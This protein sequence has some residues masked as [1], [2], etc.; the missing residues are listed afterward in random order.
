MEDRKGLRPQRDFTPIEEQ[1]AAMQVEHVAAECQTLSRVV[2]L[3]VGHRWDH[4]GSTHYCAISGLRGELQAAS[5]CG[6]A[7]TRCSRLLMS[8]LRA[9]LADHPLRAA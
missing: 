5:S 7:V 8:H 3:L 6:S 1:A 2:A 9:S 4:D